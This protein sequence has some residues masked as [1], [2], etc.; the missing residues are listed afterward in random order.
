MT[1]SYDQ[2]KKIN[3][4][5]LLSENIKVIMVCERLKQ[6]TAPQEK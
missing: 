1:A 2:R 3:R 5:T 4:V 6:P